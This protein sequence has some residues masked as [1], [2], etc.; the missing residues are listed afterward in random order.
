MAA[1]SSIQH[2]HPFPLDSSLLLSN[3]CIINNNNNNNNSFDQPNNPFSPIPLFHQIQE[4]PQNLDQ[5]SNKVFSSG[6]STNNNEASVMNVTNK[7]STTTMDSSLVTQKVSNLNMDNNQN[8]KR[9]SKEDGSSA[10]SAQFKREMKGKKQKK[11]K[12]DIGEEKKKKSKEEKKAA[13]KEGPIGYIHLRAKR[14]QATDS[15]SLAERVTGKALMLDEII[16]YVQSLQNQVEFL[17]MKL[18]SLNPM[19]YDFG[20]DLDAFM[21]RADQD[22]SNLSSQLPSM[23]ACSP[24][25]ANNYPILDSSAN[26][27]MFQQAQ[28]PNLLPQ[29]WN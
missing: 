25:I 21:M 26:Y 9:K 29:V 3:T 20:M 16:N 28:I 13:E 22:L 6:P 18:A 24:T 10:N 14:G 19:C 17:S 2:H 8:N 4:N 12:N 7:N 1:F 15:H 27:F 23:Q 5:I 11:M